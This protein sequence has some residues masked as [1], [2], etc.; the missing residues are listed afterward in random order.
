MMDGRDVVRREIQAAETHWRSQDDDS[1]SLQ[2]L[3]GLIENRMVALLVRSS[4]PSPEVVERVAKAIWRECA[5]HNVMIP[6]PAKDWEPLWLG[7][8]SDRERTMWRDAALVAMMASL[9]V[10]IIVIAILLLNE[11]FSNRRPGARG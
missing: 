2:V 11:Y 6:L 9:T 3:L 10:C 7:K 1:L 8:L 4:A 5:N